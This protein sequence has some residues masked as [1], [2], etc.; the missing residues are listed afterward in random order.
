MGGVAST[1]KLFIPW[2]QMLTDGVYYECGAGIV[3][4]SLDTGPDAVE[5][6]PGHDI[7]F[8]FVGRETL[9]MEIL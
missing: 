3:D 1:H 6:V 9:K 8:E 2:Q 7:I 5:I 4:Q